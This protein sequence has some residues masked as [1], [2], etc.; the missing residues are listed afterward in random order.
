MS[1]TKL[2]IFAI[3]YLR[4]QVVNSEVKVVDSHEF[5]TSPLTTSHMSKL[6]QSSRFCCNTSIILYNK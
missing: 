3:T 6:W 2:T 1:T 4:G 5:I